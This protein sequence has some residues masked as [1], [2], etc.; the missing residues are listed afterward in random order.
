VKITGVETSAHWIEW[1][2]WLI[3]K[4]T[5]DDGLVGWGE[6]S[7]HGALTSV[8][9]AVHE[10][11]AVL[12]GEDPAGVERHWHRMY[13]AWRWR[14]GPTLMTA[15]GALD[16]ALWDIEGKRL[17]VPV[18]RLLGG[19]FRTRLRVYASHALAGART[20]EAARASAHEII[21]RGFHGFK[22][23]PFNAEELRANEP[24]ALGRAAEMMAAAREGAG[25][26]AE[27]YVECSEL[28][29]PRTAERAA[30]LLGPY[31]PAWL[32]EP[33]PFEN[34]AELCRLRA[35]LA[36]PIATGER[37]VSRWDAASLLSG[38]GCSVLQPDVM[39]CGGITEMRRICALADNAYVSVAPH[40]PGGPI[41]NLAAM[42][43]AAAIPNF[44][45]LEEM[46]SERPLRD[47]AS[48]EPVQFESGDFVLPDRPGLG[49]EP[50]E[51]ALAGRPFRPQPFSAPSESLWR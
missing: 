29:S 21:A 15:L 35:R 30:A 1:C 8:E 32:E 47:R 26:D 22:W 43:A 31:R 7:L 11:S 44:L 20:P 37:I 19:P 17:G 24:A 25:A 38:G 33:I 46:E 12:I 40:N 10:L 42:H 13:H 5:T 16:I 4:V 3:V 2:N 36:V 50:D 28:L 39:H 9:R 23:S 41:C 51:A 45:V 14:G 48:R 34:I 18:A 6:G 49:F 27:I